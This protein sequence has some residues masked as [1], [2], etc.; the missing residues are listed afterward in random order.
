MK[1]KIDT[2]KLAL[3]GPNAADWVVPEKVTSERRAKDRQLALE[4]LA[5]LGLAQAEIDNLLSRIDDNNA[6]HKIITGWP[7][8]GADT[9]ALQAAADLAQALATVLDGLS[10][11]AH[12]EAATASLM[13]LGD[14]HAATSMSKAARVLSAALHL[15]IKGLPAQSR[16][17]PMTQLARMVYGLGPDVLGQPT[18]WQ[19]SRFYIACQ[20]VFI[21]AGHS[22]SPDNAIKALKR[23]TPRACALDARP[24]KTGINHFL[25]QAGGQASMRHVD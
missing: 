5:A 17:K 15:R 21:L 24:E 13:A 7:T 25:Q 4:Q 16:R 23:T 18:T 6:S 14:V 10:P 9:V 22:S 1:I 2:G 12:A 19:E 11:R 20:Q 8:V 3:P